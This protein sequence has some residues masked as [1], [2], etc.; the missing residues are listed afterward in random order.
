MS[1]GGVPLNR[2]G[3][4]KNEKLKKSLG[5]ELSHPDCIYLYSRPRK[6]IQFGKEYICSSKNSKVRKASFESQLE[7]R[8]TDLT[9]VM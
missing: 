5:P 8:N 7:N 6:L 9:Q 2:T 1:F 3:A 4:G